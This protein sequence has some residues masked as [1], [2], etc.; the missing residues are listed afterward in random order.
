MSAVPP[1]NSVDPAKPAQSV[2]ERIA[3]AEHLTNNQ[4][5]L[6]KTY[7]EMLKTNIQSSIDSFKNQDGTQIL[8]YTLLVTQ[9][10]KQVEQS[11]L[12]GADKKAI[13]IEVGHLILHEATQGKPNAAELVLLY[14]TFA[15]SFID[16]LVDV[17]KNVNVA[18]RS[19]ETN[20]APGGCCVIQ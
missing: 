16:Q 18:V 17:A 1:S 19:T 13:A 2:E 9:I 3:N 20:K 4:K 14:D 12:A 7:Y 6:V 15:A 11:K 10:V 5:I 8:F